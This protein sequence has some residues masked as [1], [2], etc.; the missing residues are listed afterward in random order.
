MI[1]PRSV[2]VGVDVTET[3]SI[4]DFRTV[5]DI[6]SKI[7]RKSECVKI[8]LNCDLVLVNWKFVCYGCFFSKAIV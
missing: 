1:G 8:L 3:T 5:I 6:V 2:D 7:R 4:V